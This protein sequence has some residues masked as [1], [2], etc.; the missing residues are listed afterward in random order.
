MK[1]V[2]KITLRQTRTSFTKFIKVC[3]VEY[4]LITQINVTNFQVLKTYTK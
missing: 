1:A 2:N 4:Y 3:S